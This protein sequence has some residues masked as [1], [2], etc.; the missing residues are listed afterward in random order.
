MIYTRYP[1]SLVNSTKTY[2]GVSGDRALITATPQGD[3]DSIVTIEEIPAIDTKLVA[4]IGAGLL[5]GF[6]LGQAVKGGR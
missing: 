2:F 1:T 5:V 4:A 3:G 6:L